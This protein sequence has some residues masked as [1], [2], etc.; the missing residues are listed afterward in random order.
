MR[1]LRARIIISLRENRI[2]LAFVVLWLSVHAVLFARGHP[3]LETILVV[4]GIVRD[5]S[6]WG[7]IY[8]PFTEFVVFG[9]I[10][11]MVVSNITRRYRPEATA[12]LLA[13]EAS[14]HVVIVGYTHLGE[15]IR[16]AMV[17]RGEEVVVVDQDRARVEGLSPL[18]IGDPRDPE[19]LDAAAI[20]DARVVAVTADEVEIAAV[21]ARLVRMKNPSCELIL[22]CPDDGV[23]EV[24]AK[25]H[26]AKIVST[27]RIV[28]DHVVAAAMKRGDRRA[29][30]VGDNNIG[31]RVAR[32][33][34]ARGVATTLLPLSDDPPIDAADLVLIADDDLGKNLVRIDRIRRRLPHARIVCRAFHEQAADILTKPP[35]RAEVLSS[36]R[37]ALDALLRSGV[38]SG[39]NV[40][41]DRTGSRPLRRRASLLGRN[42]EEAG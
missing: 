39:K 32:E 21:V 8:Q 6:F 19:V 4:L 17:E 2:A 42:A 12:R 23:G 24:L 27:S 34:G 33:L 11:A 36:S 18:V 1:R 16:D 10:M 14:D 13:G 22:R 7:A 31:K 41:N 5:A 38:F 20:E 29:A 40:A 9:A 25:T 28:A 15:R 3:P 37:L 26:G 35:F 30:I